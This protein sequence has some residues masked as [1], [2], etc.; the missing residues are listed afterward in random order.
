MDV[1]ILQSSLF[2]PLR[3]NILI[4]ELPKS[5]R[6]QHYEVNIEKTKINSLIYAEDIVLITK[7]RTKF[8]D[9]IRTYEMHSLKNR[10]AISPEECK[11]IVPTYHTTPE[12][13]LPII[14]TRK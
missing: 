5:I 12:K 10:C 3:I 14:L 4:Y 13:L 8:Q 11:V 2:S 9:F 6:S 7:N 1:R